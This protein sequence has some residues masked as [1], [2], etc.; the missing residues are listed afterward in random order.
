M[1]S[2]RPLAGD[3]GR[4]FP[5]PRLQTPSAWVVL[6]MAVPVLAA[7]YLLLPTTGLSRT[8]AYPAFSLIGM[9]AILVGVHRQRPDRP[10]SWLMIAIA[11]ALLAIGD[12][13]Y[14]SS[15]S[16]ARRWHTPRRPTSRTSGRMSR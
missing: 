2:L 11:L 13:V 1:S 8:I 6:L 15:P 4:R 7:F 16:T 12:S 3:V 9:I 14:R 5:R 10:R